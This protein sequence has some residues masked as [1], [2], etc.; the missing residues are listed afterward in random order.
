MLVVSVVGRLLVFH[1]ADDQLAIDRRGDDA[2]SP[3]LAVGMGE[4][5]PHDYFDGIAV[6]WEWSCTCTLPVASAEVEC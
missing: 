6:R 5:R 1:A 3:A 4:E 2:E